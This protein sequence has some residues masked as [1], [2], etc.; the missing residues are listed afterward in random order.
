MPLIDNLHFAFNVYR[1][2]SEFSTTTP[3]KFYFALQAQAGTTMN[4]ASLMNTWTNQSGYP[5]VTIE[6]QSNVTYLVSQQRFLLKTRIHTDATLWE[7]PLNYASPNESFTSTNARF[8]LER[9]ERSKIVQMQTD[10][11][12]KI[13]NIQQTGKRDKNPQYKRISKIIS[14]IL[15]Y[16]RVNYDNNTWTAIGNALKEDDHSGIHVLNRAQI[17]DDILMLA[18]GEWI[19]YYQALSIVQYLEKEENYIPWKAA[20]RNL[21]YVSERLSI[22]ELVKYRKYILALTK[23]VYT[24]LHFTQKSTDTRLDIYNR[25]KILS[26][27]CKFG[28]EECINT[29]KEEFAKFETTTYR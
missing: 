14:N 11:P 16:Y 13:F 24:K 4:I 25:G 26:E 12:W 21:E 6:R 5:V 1:F 19:D 20:L 27:A 22:T 2:H 10:T 23:N 18:R 9:T 17:V 7:I 28:H 8:M 29:A 3:E 15:G